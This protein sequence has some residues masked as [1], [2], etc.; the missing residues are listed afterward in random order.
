MAPSRITVNPSPAPFHPNG[1]RLSLSTLLTLALTCTTPLLET[2][3][4]VSFQPVIYPSTALIDSRLYVYGGLTN[5]S[6]RTSYSSQF[7]YLSLQDSFDTNNLSWEYL[8]SNISTAKAPGV[9]SHDRKRFILGGS[10]NNI[11]HAP[12]TIYDIAGQTWSSA[13]NLPPKPGVMDVMQDYHRDSPGM[14]MDPKSGILVQFGGSNATSITNDLTLLDTEGPSDEMEWSYSGSLD[15]VPPLFAPILLHIPGSEH[16]LIMGGC[17]QINIAADAGPIPSQCVTFDTLYTLSSENISITASS[18]PSVERITVNGV[19]P[20]PRFMPCAVVLPDNNVF[21][22]GGMDPTSMTAVADAWILNTQNWM[23]FKREID[24]FPVNGIMGHSCEMASRGQIL[25]IGGQSNNNFVHYPITVIRTYNWTWTSH[26]SAPGFSTGVKVGLA[27]SCVVVIGAIIA[28][29]YIRWK[30]NKA[31]A[32]EKAQGRDARTKK[33]NRNKRTRT[34]QSRSRDSLERQ[35]Q[36]DEEGDHDIIELEGVQYHSR[37]VYND[38]ILHL[39]SMRARDEHYDPPNYDQHSPHHR[40]LSV[41][42]VTGSP[43]GSSSS[44]VVVGQ[45]LP[46][47]DNEYRATWQDQDVRADETGFRLDFKH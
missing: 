16:T 14:A 46:I 33:P 12:A 13:L 43:K 44:T 11:G 34:S 10:R 40:H 25:V 1:V 39:G 38:S 47:P 45:S 41:D 20:S 27:L 29:L 5:I 2:A 3:T 35:Q 36:L 42:P 6:S 8:P 31:A 37:D 7:A 9:P 26:Y 32:L 24:S 28:G 19:F 17:D 23:W 15:S 22:M 21:M 4:A 30:R 18:P